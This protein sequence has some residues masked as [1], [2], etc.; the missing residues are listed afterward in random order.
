MNIMIATFAF[1]ISHGHLAIALF[2]IAIQTGISIEVWS[3]GIKSQF[4]SRVKYLNKLRWYIFIIGT[5]YIADGWILMD[6]ILSSNNWILLMLFKNHLLYS[7]IFCIIGLIYFIISLNKNHNSN[8]QLLHYQYG[9]LAWNL[10]NTLLMFAIS[11]IIRVGFYGIIWSILPMSTVV[12]NDIFAYGFGKLFGKHQLTLLSPKKT[13][14]GYIGSAIAT[15][16]FGCLLANL[17]MRYDVL[18]C[19]TNTF[20]FHLIQCDRNPIFIKKKYPLF[21]KDFMIEPFQFYNLIISVWIAIVCPFG[22]FL[23]SGYKRAFNLDN[24]GKLIPGHGGILDRMDC[25]IVMCG[26][27]YFI[28]KLSINNN[29]IMT[30]NDI[31]IEANKL[32][33]NDLDLLQKTIQNITNIIF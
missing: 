1:I 30:I 9:Q 21:G 25:E 28:H 11:P 31:E 17:F 7:F 6:L 32:T 19:E 26:F 8:I 3:I 15:I 12:A 2:V 4:E 10:T 33:N 16:P 18:L 27:V 29:E 5:L 14:E 22:G 20:Q 23:A 13:W 24:Y